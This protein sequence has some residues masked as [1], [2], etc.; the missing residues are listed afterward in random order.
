[1]LSPLLALFTAASSILAHPHKRLDNG[2]ALTPPMGWNSY[3]HYSCQPNQSIIESNAKALVDLGLADLG[4]YYVTTDCGWTLPERNLDGS[5]PWNE[6]IFPDGLPAVGEYIH[7]LGLGF[8]V[9]SDSGVQMCMTGQPNQTGSLG[10][11]ERDAQMFASWEADL[12]KYDNCYSSAERGFPNV[13]YAPLVSPRPRM[14]IMRDAVAATGRDILYQICEWGVDFPSAWAPP[15]GN[16]WRITND[17]VPQWRSIWRIMNQFPPSADY[18][19]PGQWPDLDMMEV[20]NGFLTEPEE[21][22]HFTLWAIAKSPLTIGCALNDTLTRISDSSLAILKNRDV[23]AVNQDSLGK[24]AN[25]ARRYTEEG[26]DVW[27]GPLSNEKLIVALVNWNNNTV[28]ATLNLPDAGTQSAGTVKDL[29]NNKTASNVVTAYP[30][31]IPA[32]GTLLL[33]LSDTTPAGVYSTDVYATVQEGRIVFENVYGLTNSD[34]YQ[35]TINLEGDSEGQDIAISTSASTDS[36][37]AKVDGSSATASI[38]LEASNNTITLTT[39]ASVSSIQVEAPN[40]KFYPSTSF[41]VS[42]TAKRVNCTPGLCSPVGS[43]IQN[44]TASGSARLSIPGSNIVGSARYLEITY[45]NSDVAL[46]TAWTNGTNSRN[47]TVAVNGAEPVRLEVPL[48]GR[49][50][51]LFSPMRGWGDPATLGVLVDGFGSGDG[52]EDEIVVSNF[53]GEDGD[54]PHGAHFVGLRVV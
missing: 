10:Y 44:L 50:S 19:G 12:L 14:E 34:A 21:Q 41:T 4:Y 30:A 37:M 8:G 52:G 9:Y 15:L 27:S 38:A 29:W 22:T 35:L 46:D 53:G 43:K 23:I 31:T 1:M 3:N 45:I 16:T 13:D 7:S 36:Q 32:H 42:G 6:T 24:A 2:L 5:L 20:G 17:I 47:I 28:Q 39:S 54:Q 11:E 18:A 49:S 25:L 51:E 26:L 40:G 48:S 33:E